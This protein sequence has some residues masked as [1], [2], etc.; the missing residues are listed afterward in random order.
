MPSSKEVAEGKMPEQGRTSKNEQ[1][2]RTTTW[3]KYDCPGD[4]IVRSVLAEAS[5]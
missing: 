2:I 1:W 5:T 4:N 3:I